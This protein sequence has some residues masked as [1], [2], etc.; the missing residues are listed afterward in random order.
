MLITWGEGHVIQPFMAAA[1]IA[2]IIVMVAAWR[3]R[4][5]TRD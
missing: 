2:T 5:R 4:V 3:K 1:F